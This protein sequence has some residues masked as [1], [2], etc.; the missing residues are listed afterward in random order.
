MAV[1]A[2]LAGQSAGAE[3][4]AR[5]SPP[6]PYV[7]QLSEVGLQLIAP[8]GSCFVSENTSLG[9]EIRRRLEFDLNLRDARIIAAYAP[10]ELKAPIETPTTYGGYAKIFVSPVLV[11][12][13]GK[14]YDTAAYLRDLCSALRSSK[15]RLEYE[16][17]WRRRLDRIDDAAS[18]LADR[19]HKNAKVGSVRTAAAVT[20]PFDGAVCVSWALAAEMSADGPAMH[21][22]IE[23]F[24]FELNG[25]HLIH[26]D[27]EGY[28]GARQVE[29]HLGRLREMS[30][31][32]KRLNRM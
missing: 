23:A 28:S 16:K 7:R 14:N 4:E 30:R 24:G 29:A 27:H 6:T 19:V 10:C 12:I 15:S 31:E 2:L 18:L 1:C 20:L 9:R 8:A 21:S 13:L 5:L 22:R 32:L 11:M 26:I 3:D 25:R 17:A